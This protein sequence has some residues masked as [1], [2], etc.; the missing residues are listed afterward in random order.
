MNQGR[1]RSRGRDRDRDGL[2]RRDWHSIAK[3]GNGNIKGINVNGS[4]IMGFAIRNRRRRQ[5]RTQWDRIQG[6]RRDRW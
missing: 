2:G 3:R 6:L 4:G 1:G 5:N